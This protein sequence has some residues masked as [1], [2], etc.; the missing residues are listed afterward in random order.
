MK[1]RT[2]MM[3]ETMPFLV[4]GNGGFRVLQWLLTGARTYFIPYYAV[5]HIYTSRSV[6]NIPTV[7]TKHSHRGNELF[8]RREQNI[9]T[10]GMFRFQPHSTLY[11]TNLIFTKNQ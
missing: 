10:V 7:G 2:W 6:L 5:R 9:P 1:D 3:M 4:K 8:P 11:S